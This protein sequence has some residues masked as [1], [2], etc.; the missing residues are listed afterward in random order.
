[1][2]M[3]QTSQGVFNPLRPGVTATQFLNKKQGESQIIV[4]NLGSGQNFDYLIKSYRKTSTDISKNLQVLGKLKKEVEKAKHALSS[5]QSVRIE[6][7]SFEDSNVLM[8]KPESITIK[9][10]KG[11]LSQ[12]EIKCMLKPSST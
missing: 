7:E 4:Y 2:P 12:E 3:S 1:M 9:N 10:A 11:R 8:T 5:Q 6:I